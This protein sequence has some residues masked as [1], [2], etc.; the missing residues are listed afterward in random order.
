M[1]LS[2]LRLSLAISGFEPEPARTKA[3]EQRIKIGSGFHNKWYAS[4]KEHWLGWLAGKEAQAHQ[5][6]KD[7]A[8]LPAKAIWSH[9]KCSPMM[10]WLAEVAGVEEI[11]LDAAERAAIGAA[12][13]N[14][15][16]GLPHGTMMRAALPWTSI[17]E[18][19]LRQ[20]IAVS[21]LVAQELSRAALERLIAKNSQYRHLVRYP[22]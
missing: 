17:E 13:I 9:L 5:S 3:L 18:G 21:S 20:P 1:T 11:H 2:Q 10:F 22:T 4:Q 8:A 16:D 19:I 12:K 6:S 14:P 15:K 7:P